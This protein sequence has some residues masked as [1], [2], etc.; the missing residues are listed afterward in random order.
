MATVHEQQIAKD[1]VVAW[2]SL[3]AGGQASIPGLQDPDGAAD[4]LATM[5][6]T[7][8]KA[9]SDTSSPARAADATA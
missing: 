5:Y 4:I 3:A 1:I 2:L 7:L 9:V 6:K 8:V